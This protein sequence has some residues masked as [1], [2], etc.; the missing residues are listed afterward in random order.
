MLIE[1]L[2]FRVAIDA[3]IGFIV[4][5]AVIRQRPCCGTGT[6]CCGC[7]RR[8]DPSSDCSPAR[9]RGGSRPPLAAV[10]DRRQSTLDAVAAILHARQRYDHVSIY[11]GD[12]ANSSSRRGKKPA[13]LLLAP[14]TSGGIVGRVVRQ[15]TPELVADVA[16]D[17][18]YIVGDPG[19][20]SEICV[21]LV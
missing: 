4:V 3:L 13:C 1:D 7:A 21:P 20:R 9:W 12:A 17:P 2:T 18:D 8:S 14:S 15:R 6:P 16:T 10:W 11:L 19:V 5:G